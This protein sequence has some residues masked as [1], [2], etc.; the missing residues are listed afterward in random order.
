MGKYVC[1]RHFDGDDQKNAI[2]A[3]L[4][5]CHD[6]GIIVSREPNIHSG[7]F[8]M[9]NSFPSMSLSVRST[10]KQKVDKILT[11]FVT[12]IFKEWPLDFYHA[13]GFL[14]PNLIL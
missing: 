2:L 7:S 11:F 10:I 8:N 1:E 4:I 9:L 3:P 14:S 6:P 5:D 12:C 13:T